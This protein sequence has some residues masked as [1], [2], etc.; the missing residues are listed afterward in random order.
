M[1][2]LLE[3]NNEPVMSKESHI[4]SKFELLRTMNM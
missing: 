1:K 3:K 4:I 2:K